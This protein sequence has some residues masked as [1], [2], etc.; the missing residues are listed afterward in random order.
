L[1]RQEDLYRGKRPAFDV[2][3]KTVIL[4]DD[5]IATG[6]TMR[7]AILALRQQH[8][9]RI[10]VAVSVAP[11]TTCES[12][13]DEADEVVCICKLQR[14]G[15]VSEYYQNFSQVSDNEVTDLL[16]RAALIPGVG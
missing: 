16:R 3:G 9:S 2:R 4:V 7:A 6:S 13:R 5:G 8:S 1:E 11:A 14:F 15:S 12:L 10:V